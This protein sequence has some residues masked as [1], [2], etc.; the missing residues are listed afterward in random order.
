MNETVV[1]EALQLV[2]DGAG[3]Y[4]VLR[5]A[6]R[7][8][9]RVRAARLIAVPVALGLVVAGVLSL[10]PTLASLQMAGGPTPSTRGVRLP[11]R[12]DA[13][14]VVNSTIADKPPGPVPVVMAGSRFPLS[15]LFYTN[16]A[17]T[18]SGAGYRWVDW[19]NAWPVMPGENLL[20]A[21]DGTK[22]AWLED[23]VKVQ[24]LRTG[25]MRTVARGPFVE[26]MAYPMAW[27][28]DGAY[29]AYAELPT[30]TGVTEGRPPLVGIGLLDVTTG[31][32][33]RVIAATGTLP[34]APGLAF[35]PDGLRVAYQS[36]DR[37]H[38]AGL[39]RP[40]TWSAALPRGALLAGKG[41][42]TRDGTAV[43]IAVPESCCVAA[44]TTWR[45]EFLGADTGRP[46][47]DLRFPAVPGASVIR[48]VGWNPAG[49]AVAV[50]H[51]GREDPG[52]LAGYRSRTDFQLVRRADLIVLRPGAGQV[53]VLLSAPDGIEMLDVAEDAVARGGVAAVPRTPFVFDPRWWW[54]LGGGGL[55]LTQIV[56]AFIA[57]AVMR[58]RRRVQ[59]P[60]RADRSVGRHPHV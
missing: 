27:T 57:V 59:I 43:A 28:P 34:D 25:Q 51:V 60:G 8:A 55:L 54:A 7:R 22:V 16:R 11:D 4:P 24:D 20:L 44:V 14:G 5:P 50:A 23:G 30:P 52:P 42:W 47:P 26:A 6:L 13:P 18:L 46:R 48:L 3:D 29:L 32:Y 33:R 10:A 17:V 49:E 58:T 45:L 40:D 19:R 39:G 12:L 37:V 1:R 38:V 2:A 35:S 56:I 31:G 53:G 9:R 36:G 21:P 15:G 41:A